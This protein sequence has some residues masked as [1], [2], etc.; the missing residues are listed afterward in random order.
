MKT[1]NESYQNSN[2]CTNTKRIKLNYSKSTSRIYKN[3]LSQ[4][5]KKNEQYQRLLSLKSFNIFLAKRKK[6]TIE[7]FLINKDRLEVRQS[8]NEN[9]ISIKTITKVSQTE[10]NTLNELIP[11]TPQTQIQDTQNKIYNLQI[12]IEK[13]HKKRTRK[14][15]IFNYIHFLYSNKK[16][17]S[18]IYFNNAYE[19]RRK[20]RQEILK[21]VHQL[22]INEHSKLICGH[23]NY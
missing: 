18:E 14:S 23:I 11:V 2:Y 16:I 22:L 12:Q 5:I 6:I 1:T 7:K 3:Y 8:I 17:D 10:I 19:I 4:I 15:T 9:S 21:R 20:T 13:V